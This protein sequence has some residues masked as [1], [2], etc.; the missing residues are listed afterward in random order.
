M[1]L[2]VSVSMCVSLSVCVCVCVF[3]C[4]CLCVQLLELRS[5]DRRLSLLH[6]IAQTVIDKFP[7]LVR[8]DAELKSID[9]ASLGK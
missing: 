4:V 6:F 7:D 8:F 1:C 2:H 9:Q 5:P 3:V